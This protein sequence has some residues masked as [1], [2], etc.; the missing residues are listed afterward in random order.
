MTNVSFSRHVV[1]AKME[2]VW[3][4]APDGAQ[5]RHGHPEDVLVQALHEVKLAQVPKRSSGGLYPG[6]LC[7]LALRTD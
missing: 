5:G 4:L 7:S 6:S 3:L 2:K 1:Y